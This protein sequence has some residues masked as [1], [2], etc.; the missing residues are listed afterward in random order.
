MEHK[1]TPVQAL[2]R[3]LRRIIEDKNHVTSTYWRAETKAECER[4][5]ETYERAIKLLEGSALS[6]VREGK[7]K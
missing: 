1:I 7:G 5:I 4:V 6:K 3:Q 2:Q